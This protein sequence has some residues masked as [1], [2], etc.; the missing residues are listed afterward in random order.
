[1]QVFLP[2]I[3]SHVPSKMVKAVQAFLD[4]CYIARKNTH[5]ETTLF[6]LKDALDRF[7]HF[8]TIFQDSGVRPQGF[9]LPAPARIGSL[10]FAYS[11]IWCTKWPM[12]VDYRIQTYQSG[13]GTMA[14]IKSL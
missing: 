11:F 8:R 14:S 12:L 7:H 10:F 2:A 5:D 6:K 3:A 4:F 13:Q 9:S 1:M